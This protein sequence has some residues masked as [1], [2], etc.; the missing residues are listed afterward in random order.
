MQ[1]LKK[2][3]MKH[4]NMG[5]LNV[6]SSQQCNV[7][8]VDIVERFRSESNSNKLTLFCNVAT[9]TLLTLWNGFAVKAIQIN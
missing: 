9:L 2:G 5:R 6:T 4:C 1:R 3:G 8:V 7:D